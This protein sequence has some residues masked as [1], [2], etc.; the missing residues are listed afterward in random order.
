M[1]NNR[2][3]NWKN[4]RES[5]SFW[6]SYSDLMAGL[7]LVFILLLMLSVYNYRGELKQIEDTLKSRELDIVQYEESLAEKE[8]KIQEILGVKADIIKALTLEFENSDITVDIDP[9]TGAIK[10][11]GGVFFQTDQDVIMES[12]YEMLNSFFPKYINVLL[13]P[14]YKE[15][16]AQ[17]IV[18]GH[19]DDVGSYTYNL[20]LS[21]RRAFSVVRAV[22]S[23]RVQSSFAKDD[24]Q[25]FLTSN[26]RSYSQPVYD[27]NGEYSRDLSR[28]VEFKFR[29]KEDEM[30]EELEKLV[31]LNE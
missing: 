8:V 21:Q 25:F 15:F 24:L 18:E 2:K 27:E 29:L 6:M 13:S 22:L 19:T 5:H 16:I 28:R 3:I 1:R 4:T 7:L 9:Q 14:D 20:D 12:G 23:D 10:F 11:Q 30:I 26:G 31:R 17:I